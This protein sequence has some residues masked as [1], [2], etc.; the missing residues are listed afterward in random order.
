MPMFKRQAAV[1]LVLTALALGVTFYLWPQGD[2]LPSAG[3]PLIVTGAGVNVQR[4]AVSAP[5]AGKEKGG[6]GGASVGTSL[7]ITPG[8]KLVVFVTGAV[9]QPGVFELAPGSRVEDAVKAAGG[10]GPLA[11]GQRLNLAQPVMDGDKVEVPRRPEAL[12][13]SGGA[14]A[15]AAAD[16]GSESGI[17][18][19]NSATAAQLESLPG[20]GPALAGRIVDYRNRHGGFRRIEDIQEVPGIGAG[21]FEKMRDRLAL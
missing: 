11:D 13:E 19:L 21:R 6:D 16:R 2:Q 9:K 17:V 3:K 4:E 15:G 5:A 8:G 10:F 12:R 14:V 1:L 7:Q 18:R 20:I